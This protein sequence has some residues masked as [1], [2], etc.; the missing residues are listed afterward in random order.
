MDSGRQEDC[1]GGPEDDWDD[2]GEGVEDVEMTARQ[3]YRDLYLFLGHYP[4]YKDYGRILAENGNLFTAT[5]FGACVC[6]KW[7]APA[8]LFGR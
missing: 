8:I 4:R 6:V 5:F 3:L 7:D 2:N 1:E